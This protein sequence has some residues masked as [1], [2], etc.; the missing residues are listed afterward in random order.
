[1]SE[2][3]KIELRSE[4]VRNIIGKLPN[5]IIR[6]GMTIMSIILIGLFFA[7][8]YIP[9]PENLKADATAVN[10][11]EIKIVIPYNYINVIHVGTNVEIEFEGYQANQYGYKHGIINSV[12]EDIVDTNG[13]NYFI[14]TISTSEKNYAIKKGM[15]GT[16][17]ILISDKTILQHLLGSI[18]N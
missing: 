7:I 12:F 1:M 4:K 5:K 16:A 9:Y 2:L 18:N 10:S 11:N 3:E 13:M 15:K 17:S 6:Y 8:Y 14:A